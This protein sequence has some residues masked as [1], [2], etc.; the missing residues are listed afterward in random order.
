LFDVIGVIAGTV[1]GLIIKNHIS[2]KL[3]TSMDLALSVVS[4]AI[5]IGLL[6]KAVHMPVAVVAFL[7][8]G[9][10][11][12]YCKIDFRL[13]TLSTRFSS[14]RTGETADILL[15]AFTLY[16]ISTTGIIG[17]LEL[18][19]SGDTTVLVTKVIMD[20]TASVF[21]GA[22]SGWTLALISIPLFG[23]LTF[24]Y[25]IS[26]WLMPCLTPDMIGDFSACGGLIQL[27]NGLRI[28]KVKNPP[29]AD[30]IPALI[31]V[32]GVN[33]LWSNFL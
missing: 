10:S 17:A 2:Q 14:S 26:T 21:F 4:S 20:F 1:L 5:G 19:F 11:G 16:C 15:T 9:V 23:I 18:G 27:L 28:A 22:K 7:L 29:V 32:F 12:Y 25:A 6:Q 3:G 8:G 24:F 30:Y 13:K 33:M 31:L